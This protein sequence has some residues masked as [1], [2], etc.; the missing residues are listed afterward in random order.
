MN[1]VKFKEYD[2]LQTVTYANDNGHCELLKIK[3]G[4][5]R[6]Y[7][8]P[9]T[10]TRQGYENPFTYYCTSLIESETRISNLLERDEP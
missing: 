2:H 9:A 3:R 4:V 1:Y 6:I 8:Y 10:R 7:H 5:Y